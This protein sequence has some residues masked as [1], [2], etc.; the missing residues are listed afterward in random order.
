MLSV[1][2]ATTAA[3]AG[4]AL[5][6]ALARAQDTPPPATSPTT[7]PPGTTATITPATTPPVSLPPV[8]VTAGRGSDLEKLDVSTTVLTRKEVEAM[9]ETGI[10]QVINR[11]PGI[12]TYTIPS[13]Q[14]H[15]TGQPVSIRG[16]GSS[17][18]IN[19]LVM[20]DGV[21]I[22][23]PY[24]RTVDWT[25][26]SKNN[27][28]RVEVIRG[29][30][31]TS[32]WGNMAMG[33]VINIV[34][35]QP[36][37]TGVQADVSYGMYNTANANVGGSALVN[38]KLSVG[39][40]YNHFQ[41]SGYNLTPAQYQNVNLVP[42]ANKSDNFDASAYFNSGEN[43]KLFAK[44]YFH[45]AFEDGLVWSLS[46]NNWSNYR[47]LLGGSYSLDEKSSIAFNAWGAGGTF[48]TINTAS[49]S[50]TLNTPG[51]TNQFVSQIESAPYSDI[52]GS[53]FYQLEAGSLRDVKIGVDGR[54][55]TISDYNNL[56]ASVTAAP[57][58][59]IANGEHRF[60]GPVRPGHVPLHHRAGRRHDRPAR[61]L[62]AG[63][64]RQRLHRQLG[65]QQRGPQHQ[66]LELR[67]AHRSEVLRQRGG[68]GARCDLPQL[69]R[70][71]HEP[72]VPQLRQRH[73]LHGDQPQP[74][75]DDQ[76]RPGSRH[77][78]QLEGLL[79]VG[80]LLQQ[81][82]RQLHRLRHD[83]Q[84]QCRLC[85]AVHHR[86][87]PQPVLHDG[88][89]VQQCRQR[90]LPGLRA[91]RHLA[92][93]GPAQVDGGLRQHRRLSYQLVRIRRWN[94]PVFSSARCPTGRS[95]PAP[96]GGPSR[97]WPSPRPCGR[98]RPTGTTRAIPS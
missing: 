5:V 92:G 80:H 81:Q 28:E 52:G 15:P 64:Q 29:G 93:A 85:R 91:D 82:P 13:G 33:G 76:L 86:R 10:D 4:L 88:Q 35:R 78:L 7:T 26:I 6:P 49:G 30:G 23:D 37:R 27:I 20:L 89:P 70:S 94:G 31:A 69:L 47:L 71:R 96:N 11:I 1:R 51:F 36:T 98:S 45:Q 57:S 73:V 40:N 62:L 75:A 8:S 79:A 3:F 18:T 55:T 54:R 53:A 44:A 90:H 21:P 24:F 72:D 97:N 39:V 67:S 9:P 74:A 63:A 48:G 56:Y 60:R 16:F 19:T 83:L 58:T 95:P 46:H 2:A 14:L 68:D 17:T 43:L 34:T 66:R 61:R 25:Q 42:T 59:F 84:H 22:N 41:S 77:G 65:H 50:Y 12:W 87:G 32:L 38:D